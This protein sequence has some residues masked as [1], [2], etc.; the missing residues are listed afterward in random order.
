M[1]ALHATMMRFIENIYLYANHYCIFYAKRRS[2]SH[3][4][5]LVEEMIKLLTEEE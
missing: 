5:C 1:S 3:H 2:L 4:P